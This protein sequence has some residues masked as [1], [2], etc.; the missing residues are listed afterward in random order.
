[1]QY[2]EDQLISNNPLMDYLRQAPAQG[3]GATQRTRART[4]AIRPDSQ[5]I[6][7]DPFL[8][9]AQSQRV[10]MRNPKAQDYK[11]TLEFNYEEDTVI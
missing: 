4:D 10:R 3:D 5:G 1:M 6:D 2:Q 8:Q 11:L 7:H 9:R